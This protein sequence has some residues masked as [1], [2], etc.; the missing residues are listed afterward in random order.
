MH[1][2]VVG[3]I[4]IFQDITRIK[5]MEEQ[6]KLAD[7]MVSIGQMAAGIAH[8][9]RNP[10]AS[11]M[12]SIQV[13][14]EEMD[15][16]PDD[17]NLMNI[18][19]RESERLNKLVS[20]FLLF[21]HPPRNEFVP[22]LLNTL[23]DE[24]LHVLENSP[25]FNGHIAI[26]RVFSDETRILGDA[27]Q[28]K[29]VLWN[30]FLNAVQEMEDGGHLRIGLGHGEK[31]VTLTVSDT[32]AGI[33]RQRIG[34]I[35]EPF[36]TTKESGTGLGLAIV[37]RIIESHGGTIHVESEPGRGTSFILRFPKMNGV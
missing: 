6:I 3:S 28:L 16:G 10:L 24:T 8:E 9:I 20:D 18:A 26:S 12:G 7:R 32:G 31:G 4:L 27:N 21:A 36:F 1:G 17:V 15:P 37:H 22:V 23:I 25:R 35:F 34:K 19:I 30:L 11:L 2:V 5:E 14:K 13:L 33:D 29:Q